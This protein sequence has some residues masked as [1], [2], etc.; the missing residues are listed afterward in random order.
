L[1]ILSRILGELRLNT[2]NSVVLDL[3]KRFRPAR[4]PGGAGIGTPENIKLRWSQHREIVQDMGPIPENWKTPPSV[5]TLETF[6][7]IPDEEA[8]DLLDTVENPNDM[9]WAS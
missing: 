3:L 9:P 6:D 5:D 8:L 2:T 7:T 4:D 1:T